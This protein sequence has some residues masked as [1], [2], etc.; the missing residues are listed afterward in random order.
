MLFRSCNSVVRIPVVELE[1]LLQAPERKQPEVDTMLRK[2]GVK[3]PLSRF[4][5]LLGPGIKITY[6]FPKTP[7]GYVEFSALTSSSGMMYM[8]PV[9]SG[10]ISSTQQMLRAPFKKYSDYIK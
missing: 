7:N 10:P 6:P 8:P 5:D 3:S 9:F 1:E 2:M 4:S